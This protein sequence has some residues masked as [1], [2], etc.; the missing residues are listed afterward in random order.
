MNNMRERLRSNLPIIGTFL[1]IAIPQMV[2]MI[3]NADL[4]FIGV[5][6][7]HTPVGRHQLE[8]LVR[9]GDAVGKPTL[10]RVPTHESDWI[11]SALDAGAAG[12]IAPRI[13]TVEQAQAA[14]SAF[15]FPPVGRRG[16][17]PSRATAYGQRLFQYVESANDNLVLALMI[18]TADGLAN[19]EKIVDVPGFDAIIIGPGD[20]SLSLGAFTPEGRPRLE[21][22]IAKI[23]DTCKAKGIAV[24]QFLFDTA[25]VRPAIDRGMTFII[26]PSDT[27]FI[28]RG[29][30][31][32]FKDISELRLKMETAQ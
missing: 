31:T 21:A 8:E 11:A 1:G 19:L 9:A 18:E 20:L 26:A 14:V 29:L 10:I 13:E 15:R 22:A 23:V 27:L 32:A 28:Q 17:G 30:A 12:I 16:C 3:G 7:E 25:E 4:D 5:D 6:A 2:E 24:G